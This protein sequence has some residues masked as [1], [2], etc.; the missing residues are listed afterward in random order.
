[1][2]LEQLFNLHCTSVTV[3]HIILKFGIISRLASSNKPSLISRQQ[4][5]VSVKKSV[6]VSRS[7]GMGF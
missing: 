7:V 2:T 3:A 1:M 6:I 5:S 4:L